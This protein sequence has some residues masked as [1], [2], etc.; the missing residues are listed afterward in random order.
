MTIMVT[1]PS[2]AVDY[3]FCL[4]QLEIDKKTA[5]ALS[6]SMV[7]EYFNIKVYLCHAGI[8]RILDF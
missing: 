5:K 1:C 4:K 2:Y 8:K 7:E 6:T 3:E